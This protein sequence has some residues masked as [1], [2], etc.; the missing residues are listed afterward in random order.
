MNRG[1]V[2]MAQGLEYEQC[3]NLLRKNIKK[4][5]PKENVHIITLKDLPYGDQ[6]VN[7]T[8]KLK[9]DWQVYL[10]SPFEYTIKLEADMLL[11]RS[12]EYY[13]DILEQRDVVICT[14]I[15]NY[16]QEISD[17]RAYRKF[18]DDNNLPD[19]YN[20]ITYFK[21]S[22]IAK[23]FFEIVKNVF[24]NWDAYKSILK[25]NLDEVVTT[26]W[27]YSIAT[28]ILGIEK[29]TLPTFT[30]MSFIH[31]K[32]MINDLPVEDWSKL[33]IYEVLPYSLRVNTIPQMYPFHYHIKNFKDKIDWSV[34]D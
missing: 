17:S 9:N 27:A 5:M 10:A 20:G 11:P 23:K 24:E 19:C 31:M 18:I 7:D 25:C 3:A 8:W 22:D 6:C 33:L 26:D 14:T 4:V 16:K 15:R 1:F 13:W 34:Y 32:S 12:I 2:I 29:T 21:K 28:H 30:D